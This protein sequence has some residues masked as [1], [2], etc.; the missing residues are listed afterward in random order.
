MAGEDL[1]YQ[2]PSE[3]IGRVEFLITILQA[4]GVFI[5]LY[6]VFNIISTVINSKRNMEI[7]KINENLE[8]IKII[9]KQQRKKE[10]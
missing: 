8:E 4:L 10:K 1:I 7:Q 2:L 6:I 5:I 9:L 3:L